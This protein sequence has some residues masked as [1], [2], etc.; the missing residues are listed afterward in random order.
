MAPD[1][2]LGL[3]R[4]TVRAWSPEWMGICS[5]QAGSKL[6]CGLEH[7]FVDWIFFHRRRRRAPLPSPSRVAFEL[8]GGECVVV[9]EEPVAF[10]DP[11]QRARSEAVA[12]VLGL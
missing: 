12:K 7:P 8:D 9:Q 5:R 2:A 1:T 4:A 11:Q 6:E 10:D 3:V